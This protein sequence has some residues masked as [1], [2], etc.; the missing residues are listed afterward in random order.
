MS[1]ETHQE[2][3]NVEKYERQA[4]LERRLLDRFRIAL[5]REVGA[6]APGRVLDAGC[7]E[8]I[9]AGWISEALPSVE[10]HGVDARPEAIAE[11]RSRN[12]GAQAAV[13]DLYDLP[14]GADEFDLVV[15]VEVLEH[16]ECPHDALREL[17]RVSSR[18]VLLTVPH[19]PFFRGGNL[20][21]GRYVS[22]LGSTPGH[23]NTW[24]RRG[25]T[26]MAAGELEA[27]RWWSAFPWQGI[28]STNGMVRC[29]PD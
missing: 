7:G 3:S 26:R 12:P 5:M 21:R 6:L 25:F 23:V 15:A 29:S 19:E 17:A 27:P 1:G 16:F 20:A 22:R 4:G 11:F 18:S 9:V 28:T 10:L 2:T 8:G 14:Y 24:T 13:G